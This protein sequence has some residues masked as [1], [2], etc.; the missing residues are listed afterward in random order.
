M[1]STS[2]A[3]VLAAG[4][5]WADAPP[6][7][8]DYVL[9][10]SAC[11]GPNGEGAGTVTPSLRQTGRIASLPGGRDYLMRVPGAAQSPLDDARLARL[12]GWVVE[13]LGGAS[14]PNEFPTS[15]TAEEVGRARRRPL[16]DPGAARRALFEAQVE[17]GRAEAVVEPGR[18]EAQVEPGRADGR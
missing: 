6:V 17:P 16:R 13:E 14:P 7:R 5:A 12:L 11:H 9:H 3:G 15:F 4:H 10:C 8:E 2:A 1:A 18:A